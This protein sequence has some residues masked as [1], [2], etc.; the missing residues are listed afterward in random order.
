MVFMIIMMVFTFS[1]AA[2]YF[3]VSLTINDIVDD[4]WP[5]IYKNLS[6]DGYRITK[7]VFI[8]YLVMNLT[9]A[10]LFGVM[11]MLF[12]ILA[13]LAIVHKLMEPEGKF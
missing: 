2:G 4:D 9:F 10:G 1:A 7:N 13:F 5:T 6:A 11:Y 12:I 8:E 3:Y